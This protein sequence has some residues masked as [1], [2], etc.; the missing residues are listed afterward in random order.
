MDLNEDKGQK[1][2]PNEPSHDAS[3]DGE[4]ARNTYGIN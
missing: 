4:L 1:I 3:V 2:L